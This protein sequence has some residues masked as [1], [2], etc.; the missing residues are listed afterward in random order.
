M[1]TLVNVRPRN[2]YGERVGFLCTSGVDGRLG[3]PPTSGFDLQ[4]LDYLADW[5]PRLVVW[6]DFWAGKTLEEHMS[7]EDWANFGAP[8]DWYNDDYNWAASLQLLAD[9]ADRLLVLGDVPTLPISPFPTKDAAIR[10]AYENYNLYESFDFLFTLHEK[11]EYAER[12]ARIE[13]HIRTAV[14]SMPTA[15]FVD[16]APYFING[17]SVSGPLQLVNPF[18]GTL[19]YKDYS[20]LVADGADMAEQLIRKEVFGQTLCS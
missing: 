10:F 2:R 16:V 9:R 8:Q 17:T 11:P 7:V 14:Q 1:K 5:H 15:T 6:L 20:H 4:R 13:G 3:S 19:A 18:T 12:R